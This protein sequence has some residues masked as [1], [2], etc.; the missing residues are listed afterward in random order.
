M[1]PTHAG[2]VNVC[3]LS[4]C[5]KCRQHTDKTFCSFIILKTNRFS[6]NYIKLFLVC[7]ILTKVYKV[8]FLVIQFGHQC[9][10]PLI[11]FWAKYQMETSDNYKTVKYS[12][13]GNILSHVDI[14]YVVHLHD[15]LWKKQIG[16]VSMKGQ[17]NQCYK[18]DG[19]NKTSLLTTITIKIKND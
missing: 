2:K 12:H 6:G 18:L 14:F 7:C 5:S 4:T 19:W 17:V 3:V 11:C 13:L 8:T 15:Y 10:E 16:H 9:K 1:R